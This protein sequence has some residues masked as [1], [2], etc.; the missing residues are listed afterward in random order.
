MAVSRFHPCPGPSKTAKIRCPAVV[1]PESITPSPWFLSMCHRTTL[2]KTF[3]SMIGGEDSKNDGSLAIADGSDQRGTIQIG[4]DHA[5]SWMVVAKS[6]LGAVPARI[7]SQVDQ[8]QVGF[9]STRR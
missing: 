3:G 9:S 1:T 8:R 5:R 7:A 4:E 6:G 2:G